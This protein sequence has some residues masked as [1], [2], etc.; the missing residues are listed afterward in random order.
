MLIIYFV[1]RGLN[2][3][4]Y[5]TNYNRSLIKN[6]LNFLANNF[7]KRNM[8]DFTVSISLYLT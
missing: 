2:H 4:V 6:N 5:I 8:V 7:I 3:P 1:H